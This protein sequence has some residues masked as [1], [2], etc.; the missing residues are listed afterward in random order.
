MVFT[1]AGG[2]ALAKNL[3]HLLRTVGRARALCVCVCTSRHHAGEAALITALNIASI[4]EPLLTQSFAAGERV[5]VRES[6][7]SWDDDRVKTIVNRDLFPSDLL[8]NDLYP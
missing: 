1:R 3:T 4:R 7:R 2:G 8:P 5:S 6:A